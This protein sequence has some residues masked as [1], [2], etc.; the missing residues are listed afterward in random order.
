M[1]YCLTLENNFETASKEGLMTRLSR[2]SYQ[3]IT[4]TLTGDY[5]VI[6]QRFL[7]RNESPDQ[8]RGHVVNDCYPEKTPNRKVTP[9]SYEGFVAGITKRGTRS[10][11]MGCRL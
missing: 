2:Y 3:A 8:H 5:S 4:V 1:T 9:V 6:Y 11:Q 7:A 10:L